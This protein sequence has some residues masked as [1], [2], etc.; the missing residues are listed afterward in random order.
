MLKKKFLTQKDVRHF[1]HP[2][3][4]LEK[5]A[6]RSR[7]SAARFYLFKWQFCKVHFAGVQLRNFS[8]TISPLCHSH[9]CREGL[10]LSFSLE[11]PQQNGSISY[12]D[13][14]G[15]SRFSRS[16]LLLSPVILPEDVN[17]GYE[18]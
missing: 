1:P 6:H 7:Q 3:A 15:C 9:L 17:I 4:N 10:K 13:V 5:P 14:T 12:P 8:S 16:K 11:E 2:I 18:I